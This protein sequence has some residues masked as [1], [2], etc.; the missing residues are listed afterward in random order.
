M[1]I[2]AAAWDGKMNNDDP[3][4]FLQNLYKYKQQEEL[5]WFCNK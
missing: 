2:E 4:S 3:L 5:V 1:V